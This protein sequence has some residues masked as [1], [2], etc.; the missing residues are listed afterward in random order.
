V[1]VR[2]RPYKGKTGKI[3]KVAARRARP[4]RVA[5]PHKKKHWYRSSDLKRLA[6]SKTPGSG[7]GGSGGTGAGPGN[8]LIAKPTPTFPPPACTAYLSPG[9]NVSDAVESAAPGTVFCLQSGSYP[10]LSLYQVHKA[11]LVTVRSGDGQTATMPGVSLQSVSNILVYGLK[12]TDQMQVTED[13]DNIEF[14][15]NDL[16][17]QECGMYFYG[18]TTGGHS[19]SNVLVDG[20]YIHDIDYNQSEGQSGCDGYGV[21]MVGKVDHF[22]IRNNTIKSVAEDYLQTGGGSYFTVDH[23][24]FLGPSLR[25]SHPQAHADLWQFFGDGSHLQFTNNV[26]RNTGTN[27]SLLFQEGSFDN[28]LIG[29]NLFDHDSDGYTAQLY[30]ATGM[31]F[32]DNTVVGS[33]WGVLF[34]DYAGDYGQT[35]GSGYNVQNNIFDC[36]SN[37]GCTAVSAEGNAE[38]WGTYDYNVSTDGS[39]WGPHSIKHWPVHWLDTSNYLPIGLPFAAGYRVP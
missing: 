28:V 37:D 35:G 32:I 39:A 31:T 27:E 18:Y 30:N 23:N 11:G 34:R 36:H 33:R 21:E 5:L 15:G 3:T 22:T 2:H 26:A 12:M 19:V 20:N 24:T 10:K 17:P 16:G 8:P 14:V 7:G 25:A 38:K 6:R 9:A 4:Y 13:G 1:K 29:N